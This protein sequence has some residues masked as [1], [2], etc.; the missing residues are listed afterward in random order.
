MSGQVGAAGVGIV[1]QDDIAR[2]PV[3]EDGQRGCDAIRHCAQMGGDVGGLGY[4]PP[5]RVEKRAGKV[6]ALLDVGRIACALQ[7][8][9][10]LFGDAAEPV[11]V[12]LQ[13][14][15]IGRHGLV[16]SF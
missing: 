6:E 2:L 7:G 12:Q 9:A 15:G 10:H 4:Q 8:D 5:G 11:A 14:D 13:S 3:V 1:E 16:S